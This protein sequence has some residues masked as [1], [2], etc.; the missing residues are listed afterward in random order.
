LLVEHDSFTDNRTGVV[1]LS[2]NTTDLPPSQ[3]GRCPNQDSESC[4]I[5]M[6]NDISR[7]DDASAPA[8]GITPLIGVGVD[9]QGGSYDTITGNSIT[10]EGAWGVVVADNVDSLSTAPQ[11]H[12]Q[13]GVPNIVSAGSCLFEAL[14]NRIY[15]NSFTQDGS[16]GNPTNG[17]LAM[18]GLAPVPAAPRDCFYGNTTSHAPLTSSPAQI[19]SATV[20]GQPCGVRPGTEDNPALLQQLGCADGG[21]CT[22]HDAHYPVSDTIGAVPLPALPTMPDPCAGVPRNAFCPAGAAAP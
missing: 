9:I 18:L 12:C 7:N 11:S 5:I 14:G 8:F 10:D 1:L 22:D 13:G 16:F 3:D 19:E 20:D 17:D 2:R 4:T 15:G 21:H 6:D